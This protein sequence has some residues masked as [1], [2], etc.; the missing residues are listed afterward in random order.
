MSRSTSAAPPCLTLYSRPNCGLC[1]DL[2]AAITPLLQA[3]H[4]E[5]EV[6]NIDL[7]PALRQ[8]FGHSIPVL[9][10]NA[11]VLATYRVDLDRLRDYLAQ[12][13]SQTPTATS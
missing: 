11:T 8:R 10:H 1:N 13:T 2:H 5:L 9:E 3:F 12:I 6:V 7:H 4:V